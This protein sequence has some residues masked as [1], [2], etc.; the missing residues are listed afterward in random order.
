MP[1]KDGWVE[2]LIKWYPNNE[3]STTS[4]NESNNYNIKSHLVSGRN[5][6]FRLFDTIEEM[7]SNCLTQYKVRLAKE[8]I[9]AP[10]RYLGAYPDLFQGT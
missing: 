6:F 8:R 2:H 1:C 5:N 7:C 3:I 9:I 4:P 10:I